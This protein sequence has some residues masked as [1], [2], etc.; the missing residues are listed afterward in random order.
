MNNFR[1]KTICLLF[2]YFLSPPAVY[3]AEIH[4]T[5][6]DTDTK[7]PIEKAIVFCSKDVHKKEIIKK[8]ETDLK[9]MYKIANIS[10]DVYYVIVEMD[11]AYNPVASAVEI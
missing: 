1:L 11:P 2:F 3:G 5:V 8:S 9:G 6:F 7:K 10:P 4:G